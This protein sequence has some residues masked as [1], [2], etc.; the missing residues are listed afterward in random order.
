LEEYRAVPSDQEFPIG[1][2]AFEQARGV[3]MET[4]SCTARQALDV[5]ARAVDRDGTIDEL[6]TALRANPLPASTLR[7]LVQSRDR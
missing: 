3:V 1:E 4:C 2:V 7:T 5:L 6:V